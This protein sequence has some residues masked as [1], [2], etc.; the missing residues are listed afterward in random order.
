PNLNVIASSAVGGG[1]PF[2]VV[3]LLGGIVIV[4]FVG[5]PWMVFGTALFSSV[6]TVY[7]IDYAPLPSH[8]A[9]EVALHQYLV[10]EGNSSLGVVFIVYW[11]MAFLLWAQWRSYQRL[12]VELADVRVQV[13]R[14]RRL[15]E[16]KDRFI[17]SV[18]HELR[19]PI[20]TVLGYVD[21]LMN[22]INRQSPEKVDRYIQRANRA[23]QS[24]RRLLEGILDTR[25]LNLAHEALKPQRLDILA[26]LEEVIPLLPADAQDGKETERALHVHIAPDV[27]VW[28]EPIQFQQILIN[29]L[30][31]AV[32]YSAPGTPVDISAE[33]VAKDPAGRQRW[34]RHAPIQSVVQIVVRDYG[35]GIPPEHQPLLF[36]RFMRLPR[37]LE[38]PVMG[39]GLGLYLCKTM[40]ERMGGVI[41]VE[42]TGVTGE[43]S[44]FIVQLPLPP[45]RPE[46]K[47]NGETNGE[48]KQAGG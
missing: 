29:L 44:T 21:L 17:R 23:G 22:P 32:K 31:N 14:A 18:N 24:L 7:M 5:R 40:V 25:R 26:T 12:L 39:T 38:S 43:G 10:A 27:A 46:S 16:L 15:D 36:Q 6:T 4:S 8:P 33:V 47:T 30:S 11:G 9:Y 28:A 41:R 3:F 1:G 19:T 48:T 42:S 35:L 13:E 37:D 34:F 45:D 2:T 20:M